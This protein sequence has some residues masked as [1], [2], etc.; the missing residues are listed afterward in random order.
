MLVPGVAG[1]GPAAPKYQVLHSPD[2][3]PFYFRSVSGC[4][5]EQLS[6]LFEDF[7]WWEA[8][9]HPMHEEF[10]MFMRPYVYFEYL[11]IGMAG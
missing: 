8:E 1:Q 9:T 3:G 7:H 4:Q 10:L 2:N 5:T 11:R 6:Q